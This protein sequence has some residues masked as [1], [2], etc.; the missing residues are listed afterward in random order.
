MMKFLKSLR[1]L[2][3]F[4]KNNVSR[5]VLFVGALC[6]WIIVGCIGV[7]IGSASGSAVGIAVGSFR[8]ITEGVAAGV[9]AGKEAGLSAKDTVASVKE[10]M[11][12]TEQLQVLAAGVKI[13]NFHTLGKDYVALYVLKGSA[14]FTVDMKLSTVTY[15]AAASSMI[16]DIPKPQM[17]VYIDVHETE[18]LAE[19]QRHKFA[20]S[21]KDGAKAY[22]N[23]MT[24]SEERIR[25]AINN[26]DDLMEQAMAAAKSQIEA[27]VYA[28]RG[29]VSSVVINFV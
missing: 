23:T 12:A 8:G 21:A 10:T 29:N 27:L 16:V 25:E 3:L 9:A 24:Q 20:G 19:Y 2:F 22:L 14:V 17:E 28:V 11:L 6:I 5:K 26:Y 1:K 18:K 13:T 4:C 7:A 15:D